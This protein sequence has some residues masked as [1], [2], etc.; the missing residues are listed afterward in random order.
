MNEYTFILF[1]IIWN[2]ENSKVGKIKNIEKRGH[3]WSDVIVLKI[4]SFPIWKEGGSCG[5]I[6]N[7]VWCYK[8]MKSNIV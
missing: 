4:M 6:D 8:K 2:N 5:K 1:E 7:L 3:S